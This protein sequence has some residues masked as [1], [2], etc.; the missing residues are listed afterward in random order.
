MVV[1]AMME[2]HADTREELLA[3]PGPCGIVSCCQAPYL[4]FHFL[5]FEL[6]SIVVRKQ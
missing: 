3:S 5:L 2:V 4:Q 6:R 1:C